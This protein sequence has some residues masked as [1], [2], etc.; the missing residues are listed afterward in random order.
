MPLAV[1]RQEPIP[2]Y[3]LIERIGVGGY[4]E[5]WKSEAPG[6][7]TKAV[8]LVYG[9]MD[10][11]R[12]TRE[13]KA[14]NRIK[15]VRYPFLLSLERIEVV[16]GQLI[17]VTELANTNLK[18]I[19]TECQRAGMVGVPRERL[20]AYLRD[21][22]DALDYLRDEHNLQHLD[23]KPENLLL[24]GDRVKVADF[25]L[26]RELSNSGQSLMGGL[27]PSYAP[28]EVFDGRPDRHSDQYSLAIVYQEMLTGV[29]PF[30]GRT[31]AQLAAQHMHSQPRLES[32][33]A[34]DRVVVSRA[35]SK[36]PG[37]RF[38][39]CLA[40]IGNLRKPEMAAAAAVVQRSAVRPGSH[41]PLKTISLDDAGQVGDQTTVHTPRCGEGA[42]VAV[43]NPVKLT[44]QHR[45]RPTLFLAIGGA[46]TE[47]MQYLRRRLHDRLGDLQA[48]PAVQI[49]AIDSDRSA[50]AQACSA[51][52]ASA[53]NASETL[54]L[55]LRR[56]QDYRA[57]SN[58]FLSWMSRRWIYN[59]PRSL[60]TEG[61]RPLGR[62]AMVDHAE[63]LMQRLRDAIGVLSDEAAIRESTKSSKLEFEVASPRVFIVAS[64]AGG[65]GSGMVL[66]VAYAVRQ[67]LSEHGHPDD[68]VCGI[69]T[70]HTDRRAS[71]HDLSIAN[72]LACLAELKHFSEPAGHYPGDTT[73]GLATFCGRTFH[74]GYLVHLGDDLG[75]EELS[76]RL[77]R[78][79]MYLFCNSVTPAGEFFDQC[80]A[81]EHQEH[82]VLTPETSLRSFGLCQLGLSNSDLPS[83]MADTICSRLLDDWRGGPQMVTEAKPVKFSDLTTESETGADKVSAFHSSMDRLAEERAA[84][85]GLDLDRLARKALHFATDEMGCDPGTYFAE[86]LK[87]FK[88][89]EQAAQGLATRRG[90]MDLADRM[91]G[92][93]TAEGRQEAEFLPLQAVINERL[94]LMADERASVLRE[95]VWE[96][97]DD[98][99]GRI[100]GAHRATRWLAQHLQ[101]LARQASD[102]AKL[103]DVEAIS[104]Q[105][106]LLNP[107]Q[108]SKDIEQDVES[109]PLLS[110]YFSLRLH[111]TLMRGVAKAL[112]RIDEIHLASASN[113]VMDLLRELNALSGQFTPLSQVDLPPP[114]GD[115][116]MNFHQYLRSSSQKA[117]SQQVTQ[118]VA[119]V[120]T[121]L[122]GRDGGLR[123][124]LASNAA[125]QT[126]LAETL[127]TTARLVLSQ[128]VRK[129]NVADFALAAASILPGKSSNP[130][131]Q[132]A[133]IAMPFWTRCGGAQRLLC[134]VPQSSER[135]PMTACLEHYLEQKPNLVLDA[136]GDLVF[137]FEAEGLEI[138]DLA[139]SLIG[140]RP[141]LLE[142]ASRLHT[143]VDVDWLSLVQGVGR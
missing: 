107:A 53:L 95:W 93:D 114:Q 96:L 109:S 106:Q 84:S 118:F 129:V 119:E 62:L 124:L 44:G 43:L 30:S 98:S 6:G 86:L 46:G 33:A 135:K 99:R 78:V 27:T 102:Q 58:K 87:R 59:I 126:D 66:D 137:C 4:G 19:F 115:G 100:R 7:L 55:P 18:E 34:S 130:L 35:L 15:E 48:V 38:P 41:G 9:H 64:I 89:R 67:I 11:A 117:L 81:Q 25:G 73:L 97:V 54:T 105:G 65:T 131:S 132:C 49:L 61:L 52:D 88:G 70:H 120:E 71:A 37:K 23:V 45:C 16:D 10:D 76:E 74:H 113:Q 103:Y 3:R 90:I 68:G 42:E 79:A 141:D 21:A 47:T 116:G 17:V 121:S 92:T 22:A 91:L 123:V 31:A 104:V 128:A 94:K 14:L 51:T 69:L 57:E 85:L 127:R 8:K 36:D 133:E 108:K 82:P 134:V 26:V 63:K 111:Q 125:V 136:D 75:R 39:S 29:L 83:A 80:R 122:F 56:A 50:L 24:V 138:V 12:A 1:R 28:P 72:T 20:L 139:W 110:Q 2:G 32:L 77:D 140:D 5:V 112:R 143:R 13:L 60:Q 101:R 40:F 142:I